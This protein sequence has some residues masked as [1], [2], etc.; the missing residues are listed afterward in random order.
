MTTSTNLESQ[1]DAVFGKTFALY[2]RPEMEEFVGFF[3]QRFAA[4]K[5]DPRAIFE[6]RACLDAGCGNGR[7]SIFMMSNGAKRVDF[8]D[9]SPTNIESTTHNLKSFG[10]DNFAGNLTSLE[11]LPFKD[12]SFDFVWCNGVIMHTH[13]PDACLRELARVLKIGGR[14]WI[15]VYGSGGAYWYA[16]RRFRKIVR[17]VA[18]AR[19]ISALRLLGYAPR[20]VAEYLDDW[21]VPYLRTYTDADFGTR[22]ADFGFERTVPLPRGVSYDTSERRTRYPEDAPW[23]GEGDLRYLVK[24]PGNVRAGGKPISA[25]EY[26]SEVDFDSRIPKRFAPAFDRLEQAL[27]GDPIT[28]LAACG[29]IQFRLRELMSQEGPLK[30]ESW[31]TTIEEVIGLVEKA[32]G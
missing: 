32:R 22:L 14:A 10:F 26:G 3:R 11:K 29:R 28:A 30:L 16:V 12:E 2:D 7:G 5:L 4:N 20:F 6:G 24:K 21:K 15:Y 9:I 19:C 17:D 1:H 8:A 31:E 13:N 25:S 18:P 23:L 27:E